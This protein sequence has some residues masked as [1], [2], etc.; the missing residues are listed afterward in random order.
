MTGLDLSQLKD[1]QKGVKMVLPMNGLVPW[2][3]VRSVGRKIMHSS[4]VLVEL[5]LVRSVL[6]VWGTTS[7]WNWLELLEGQRA[8]IMFVL[9]GSKETGVRERERGGGAGGRDR[10]RSRVG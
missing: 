7:Y 9:W 6:F 3:A 8:K 5:R 1:G 4:K 10:G 2:N